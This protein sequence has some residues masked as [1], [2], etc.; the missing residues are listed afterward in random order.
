MSAN[1]PT[2]LHDLSSDVLCLRWLSASHC[3]FRP[4][5]GWDDTTAH[6]TLPGPGSG[7]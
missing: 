7:A 4:P 3:E 5:R 2:V 1:D 6:E